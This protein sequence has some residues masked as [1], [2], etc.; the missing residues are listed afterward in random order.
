MTLGQ[1]YV[2]IHVKVSNDQ[3]VKDRCKTFGKNYR[4]AALSTS[5]LTAS[6]IIMLSLISTEQFK[7][8]YKL[9]NQ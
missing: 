1:F 7:H 3:H 8:Y 4:I 9:M 2:N 6:G 5:F